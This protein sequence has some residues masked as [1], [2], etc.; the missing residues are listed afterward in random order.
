MEIISAKLLT[1]DKKEY[2][3]LTFSKCENDTVAVYVEGKAPHPLDSEHGADVLIKIKDVEGYTALVRNT[4]YWCEPA[5]SQDVSQMPDETQMLVVKHKDTT[6]TVVLPVVSEKYRCV[7]YGDEDGIHLKMFTWCDGIDECNALSFVY[8]HGDNPQKLAQLCFL[9]AIKELG[10]DVLP[11]EQR[12]YPEL[13]EYLGWCSW[14]ALQIRVSEDGL[15]EKCKEFKEKNIPVKWAIIDD[16]WATVP[17]FYEQT[18]STRQEMFELMH[19]SALADFQAEPRRFPKGLK[20]TI[21]KMKEYLS[22]VGMWHPT[23]GYW[24]GIKPDTPLFERF[25][26][27]L[28]FS[29][30]RYVIKPTYE[31]YS[32][33]LSAFHSFLKECGADF[34]KVDNQSIT[35]IFYKQQG[36]VGEIARNIHKAIDESAKKYFDNRL[37]NCMGCASDNV[38][39]R[40]KSPISRCSND[41]QPESK[42]WFTHHILQCSYMCLM[43]GPVIYSDWDM[44]WTNDAQGV[45]NSV[46]RA[47]SGGPVYISD[48][49]G[50]SVREVIMPLVLN[51]GRI[52]RCQNPA[53]PTIDCFASDPRVNKKPFKLQN[54]SGKSGALAVFNLDLNEEKITG[55]I[56]PKDII[57][58][59]GEKFAVYEHISGETFTMKK[60]EVKTISLENADDFKLYTFT[61]IIDEFAVVGLKDK[62]MSPLSVKWQN[63]REYELFEDGIC[64]VYK[65]GQFIQEKKGL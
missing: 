10:T 42:Q 19:S 20:H 37:I 62:F 24:Y 22:W 23:T 40:P 55:T 15:L 64:I 13:F 29:N 28:L 25:K 47:I 33:F 17:K 30:G 50:K 21:E 27:N 6:F 12:E 44:W 43:Q 51:D 41:F 65:D 8:A 45:K 57:N 49:I 46:I 36:T 61:P 38:F 60:D 32:E 26:D 7:L 39:N 48:E 4:Q 58:L 34:I 18:Y 52:L 56:S 14:D 59:E 2:P 31:D 53:T 1:Q 5:F 54:L 9:R 35:R 3:A 11:R 16:M 63:E